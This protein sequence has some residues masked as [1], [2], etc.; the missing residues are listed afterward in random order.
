[1]SFYT[2]WKDLAE[3]ERSAKE[4][5]DFWKEYF[6]K[7]KKTYEYILDNS[8]D[9]VEGKYKEL[10]DKFE[11]DEVSFA[12]FMD[13]INSSLVQE[14]KVEKLKTDSDI[15]LEVDFKKLFWNMHEARADW[16]YDL[17]QWEE[18]L[19]DE[20]RKQIVTDFNQT[21]IA[22][23]SKVGRNDPCPCGSGKK[24]KKCCGK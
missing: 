7:E 3:E 10:A 21:K 8:K 20:T 2:D 5:A 1:M 12:G 14:I 19:D 11:M 17:P 18:I 4:T 13:G 24:Y 23:S 16:L 9:T 15:K 22:V 6:E